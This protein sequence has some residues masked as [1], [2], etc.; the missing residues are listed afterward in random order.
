MDS[1]SVNFE[2]ARAVHLAYIL[3][4]QADNRATT[5]PTF[6]SNRR[7]TTAIFVFQRTVISITLPAIRNKTAGPARFGVGCHGKRCCIIAAILRHDYRFRFRK[8]MLRISSGAAPS[9][10]R[11][12]AG[13]LG[14]CAGYISSSVI[15]ARERAAAIRSVHVRMFESTRQ[16]KAKQHGRR[17]EQ[18]RQKYGPTRM[19]LEQSQS[20]KRR[21]GLSFGNTPIHH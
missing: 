19:L 11:M 7:N 12:Q 17:R 21:N 13:K 14:D 5:A 18:S 6:A 4:R 2:P 8:G 20:S 1:L 16:R 10:R 15:S 3:I 9:V